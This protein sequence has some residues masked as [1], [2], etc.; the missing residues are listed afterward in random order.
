MN[1]LFTVAV[2]PRLARS[3]QPAAGERLVLRVSG[4]LHPP[5][6]PFVLRAFLNDPQADA[7]TPTRGN[8]HYVGEAPILANEYVSEGE[9]AGDVPWARRTAAPPR[10]DFDPP[11]TLEWDVDD[12]MAGG[13]QNATVALVLLN[14]RG[15]ALP[16]DELRLSDVQIVLEQ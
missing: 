8:P 4:V 14:S 13:Q 16:V 12:A 2:P 5:R 9:R 1:R 7:S 6:E 11:I 3:S 10:R 15:E